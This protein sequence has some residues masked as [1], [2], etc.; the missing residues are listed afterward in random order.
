MLGVPRVAKIIDRNALGHAT[1]TAPTF[2]YNGISDELIKIAPVDALVAKYCAEG[3]RVHYVRDP[4]GLEHI[5]GLANFTPLAISYIADR[6][7][8][9]DVPNDCGAPAT[10][11]AC[12]ASVKLRV[13]VK[14]GVKVRRITVRS[15]GK[16]VGLVRH[17]ARRVRATLTGPTAAVTVHVVGHRHGKR[18]RTHRRRTV[19]V[20]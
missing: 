13:H 14:R 17:R 12:T 8:G 3:A 15:R 2:F 11:A 6:F 4:A 9:K 18:V 7:A 5:Q 20:C 1:P 19:H 16:L 10:P